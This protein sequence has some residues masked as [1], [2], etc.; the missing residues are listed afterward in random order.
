M[1]MESGTKPE[2]VGE[3]MAHITCAKVFGDWSKDGEIAE[4]IRKEVRANKADEGLC[5]ILNKWQK[6][7][8][9]DSETAKIL[10]IKIGEI[11]REC[12]HL[13]LLFRNNRNKLRE[14]I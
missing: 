1:W 4:L 7:A 9:A 11:K 12:P 8:P 14:V 6:D 13:I 2:V 5:S 3:I 10:M